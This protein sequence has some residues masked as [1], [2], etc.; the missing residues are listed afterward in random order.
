MVFS[1]QKSAGGGLQRDGG[2]GAGGGHGVI[3]P[4]ITCLI[5]AASRGPPILHRASPRSAID[6]PAQ[7]GRVARAGPLSGDAS[8]EPAAWVVQRPRSPRPV[9]SAGSRSSPTL[10]SPSSWRRCSPRVPGSR[11]G[12]C[13]TRLCSPTRLGRRRGRPS[14]S[15]R[16]WSTSRRS[17]EIV[18]SCSSSVGAVEWRADWPPEEWC[19]FSGWGWCRYGAGSSF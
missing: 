14:P 2:V 17:S 19:S 6:W 8:L 9:A 18:Y 13:W 3:D 5:P 1:G 10:P 4:V 7:W 12:S 11:S 16:W 15:E